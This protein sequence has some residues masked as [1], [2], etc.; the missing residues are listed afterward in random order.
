MAL[1]CNDKKERPD[2]L[3]RKIFYRIISRISD[4]DLPVDTGDFV[5]VDRVIIDLMKTYRDSN[6]YLRGFIFSLGYSR[7]GIP[8]SRRARNEG[9]SKFSFIKNWELA[10]DG[11]IAQ[12]VL[13]LK[14]ASYFGI[15]IAI[16]VS[17]LS[18]FYIYL[19]IFTNVLMP[20]GFTTITLIILLSVSMNAIFLGI[21]G[22]YL[23]RIYLLQRNNH[24]ALIDESIN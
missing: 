15:F 17:L 8:Y 2:Q 19:K 12:S 23:A 5:L 10:L 7:K 3:F 16:G 9:E 18:L 21:I 4:N 11:I 1:G 22:E 6:P 13:P 20:P 14:L 24:T